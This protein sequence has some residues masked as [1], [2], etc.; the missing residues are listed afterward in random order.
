MPGGSIPKHKH[1]TIEHEQFVLSGSMKVCIGDEVK[2]ISAGQAV[3]I[4]ADTSHWYKNEGS[5]PVEFLCVIPKTSGYE[6]NWF[7]EK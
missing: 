7:E 4:P 6:T 2:E 1:P 5:E 3:F